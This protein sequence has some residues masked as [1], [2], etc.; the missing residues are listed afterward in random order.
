[1]T[2][3]S[4]PEI[5]PGSNDFLSESAEAVKDVLVSTGRGL[6]DLAGEIVGDVFGSSEASDFKPAQIAKAASNNPE[7]DLEKVAK[8]TRD[9]VDYGKLAQ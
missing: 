4:T 5:L 9:N 2:D 7:V 8:F 3:H 1:M 6:K